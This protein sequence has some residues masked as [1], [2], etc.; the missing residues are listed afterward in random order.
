MR[1]K[2]NLE[3][4]KFG[5]L[6]VVSEHKG[7]KGRIKWDCEC[8]CGNL[9]VVDGDHLR[10]GNIRSCGCLQKEA[11]RAVGKKNA[12][13]GEIKVMDGRMYRIWKTMQQRCHNPNSKDYRYYGARGVTVCPEWRNDFNAFYEWSTENG[14]ASNLT[15]D[16][17]NNE[18]NYEPDN[19]RWVTMAIQNQNK[20]KRK[21]KYI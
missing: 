6:T 12:K 16:R 19:C 4:Q 11:I 17:I 18:G 2:K 13:N 3:G 8:D 1:R 15:I 14:Y 20:R 7:T 21:E 10:R 5:R 9:T